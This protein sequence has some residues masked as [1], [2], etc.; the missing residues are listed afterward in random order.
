MHT[1]IELKDFINNIIAEMESD[2]KPIE[3]IDF[4][5]DN[6]WFGERPDYSHGKVLLDDF[7]V[8][9]FEDPIKRFLG[10][11]ATET[12]MLEA[13]IAKRPLTGKMFSAFVNDLKAEK[14]SKVKITEDD[15]FHIV[16]FLLARLFKELPEYTNGEAA[17]LVKLATDDLT[18]ERGVLLIFFLDTVR[19]RTKTKYTDTFEMRR[20]TPLRNNDAYDITTFLSLVY[21]LTNQ[22]YVDSNRMYAKA[23]DSKKYIDLWLYMSFH[24]V[25]AVRLTDLERIYHP[26]LPKPPEVILSEIRAGTFSDS[27]AIRVLESVNLRM[28]MLRFNV[29]KTGKKQVRFSVPTNCEIHFGKLLAIA[30][31]HIQIAGDSD[32][33]LIKKIT[34][35]HSIKRIMG[36][37]IGRL[38]LKR[39]FSPRAANKS[40]LQAIMLYAD[41]ALDDNSAVLH[42][43]IAA[44]ARSHSGGRGAF[45]SDSTA[46]YLKDGKFTSMNSEEIGFEFLQRG[47]LS[48]AASDLFKLLPGLAYESLPPKIQTTV[49]QEMGISA[50]EAESLVA[51]VSEARETARITAIELYQSTTEESL[52]DALIRIDNGQAF[53]KDS[54][55]YCLLRAF[56][57]DCEHPNKRNCFACKYEILTKSTL[58]YLKSEYSRIQDLYRNSDDENER[59]MLKSIAINKILPVIHEMLICMKEQYPE[60]IY[61]AYYQV[62]KEV[63]NV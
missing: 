13:L 39:D 16:D 15:V 56:G 51:I 29:N 30:E 60:E 3:I 23:A 41:L 17:T 58:W 8:E 21:Y 9:A 48:F 28:N 52:V 53:S 36:D 27:D 47:V 20:R 63:L 38:F 59:D 6:D 24:F 32:R 40:Y 49:H 42:Y 46:I 10:L 14:A 55:S 7:Q 50:F 2:A 62:I 26:T 45:I 11:E 5:E 19:E 54:C 57:R 43:N 34:D 37:E 1:D 33:P 61:N 44:H 12:T 4:L 31:A 35:Y 22:E 18:K 25:S